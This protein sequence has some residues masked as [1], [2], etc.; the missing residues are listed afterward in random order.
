[1]NNLKDPISEPFN[2][3]RTASI[4]PQK[5]IG[6]PEEIKF[7][8]NFPPAVDELIQ[9]LPMVRKYHE[10]MR[11]LSRKDVYIYVEYINIIF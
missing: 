4:I 5:V 11:N 1:M 10:Y 2:I 8:L 7:P 6:T 9:F 3:N